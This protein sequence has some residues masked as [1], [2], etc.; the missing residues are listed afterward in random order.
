MECKNNVLS[1]SSSS[2]LPSS[3]LP[4]K[5]NANG[6]DSGRGSLESANDAFVDGAVDGKDH[7]STTTTAASAASAA[8]AATT[9]G[10]NG[11]RQ[12]Q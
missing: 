1:S 9:D 5:M 4:K 12:L 8:T 6:T 10:S 7:E 11:C 2:F 3:F